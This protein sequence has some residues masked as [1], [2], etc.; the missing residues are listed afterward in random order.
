MST[1]KV[2]T[3]QDASGSNASTTAQIEQ[4]RAKV[5]VN[6]N[7]N[8]FGIRDSFNVGSVTD[9]GTGQ[10]TINFATNMSNDDYCL[11]VS[12]SLNPHNSITHG[13]LYI[14]D[15]SSQTTS[16]VRVHNCNDAA[17]SQVIDKNIV[18]V[19]IFGDQ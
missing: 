2:D 8:S 4:G 10:Y 5:W 6:F 14:Y 19:S 3:L 17:S 15:E 1:L 12:H 11:T 9:H 16:G 13:V 18:C 7:G